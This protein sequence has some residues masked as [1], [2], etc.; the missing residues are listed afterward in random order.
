MREGL[1]IH[2][3]YIPGTFVPLA[4][5]SN[6]WLIN[7]QAQKDLESF[8]GVEGFSIQDASLQESMGPIQDYSKEHLVATDRPI[9]MV[10]RILARAACEMEQGIR[11]P[12]LDAS[13]QR[14]RAASVLLDRKQ[15]AQDWAKETLTSLE[16]PVF[17]V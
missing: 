17:T 8:S 15:K 10:R 9:V 12:A 16:K 7:R 13:T 1:G 3:K 5:P 6:D 14:V 11:P 2:V 4:N